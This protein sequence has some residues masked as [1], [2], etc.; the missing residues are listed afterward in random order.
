VRGLILINCLSVVFPL[1]LA[2]VS[3]ALKKQWKQSPN[4]TIHA[5]MKRQQ[6]S[7]PTIG[8]GMVHAPNGCSTY[9]PNSDYGCLSYY[10]KCV[11]IG[12]G[13]AFVFDRALLDYRNAE[14]LDSVNKLLLVTLSQHVFRADVLL[15]RIIF[16]DESNTIL[17]HDKSNLFYRPTSS[18]A[19]NV[20]Q[21]AIP[22]LE[23]DQVMVC[24]PE[25]LQAFYYEPISRLT[26]NNAIPPTTTSITSSTRTPMLRH[27]EHCEG[28]NAK[29]T[30]DYGCPVVSAICQC[31][32]GERE[33][34]APARPDNVSSLENHFGTG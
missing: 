27:C 22:L 20:E 11:S 5:T 33:M 23:A 14:D 26:A 31:M 30:C 21:Q 28:F 34:T 13:V 16:L 7:T 8:Y 18:T 32:K 25:W 6:E 15:N 1:F 4:P 3:R 12:C 10:L 9:I 29:C 17:P 24:S 19:S 2:K